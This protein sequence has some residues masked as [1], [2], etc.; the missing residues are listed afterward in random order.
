MSPSREPTIHSAASEATRWGQLVFGIICMV[1]I[2]NLQYGWTLFVGPIDAE[3]SLGPGGDS[4][5][6]HDFRADGDLAGPD[7]R[8]SDRQVRPA[9]HDQ[10]QRRS[11]R[12]RVGH[13]LGRRLAVPVVCRRGDRRHRSRRDLRR[14]GRQRAEMV[15]RSARPRRRLDGSGLRRRLGADGDPDCQHDPVERIRIRVPVVRS[16]AG[17]RGDAC[18]AGAARAGAR[19]SRRTRGSG[20]SADAARLHVRPRFSRR[21]YSGSCMRCS[22]WSEPAA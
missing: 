8:L 4:G 9:H 22:S 15:P 16:R 11:G 1:M 12:D 7:R 6:L 5:R 13:Q 3:I 10:R 18:R 20:C 21:R 14:R 2:A 19:R 17:H